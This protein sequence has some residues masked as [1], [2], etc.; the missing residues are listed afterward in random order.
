MQRRSRVLLAGAAIL[1]GLIAGVDFDRTLVAM[2]AWQTVGAS[3]WATFSRQADL[4]NGLVLYPLEAIGAFLLLIAV[5]L[6]L[7][8]DGVPWSR[9]PL[10]LWIAIGASG[11][12]LLLTLVAAPIMFS[13]RAATETALLQAALAD[14]RFFGDV[15]GAFQVLAFVFAVVALTAPNRG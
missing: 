6:S 10:P 9:I 3:A 14:F 12:G 13:I 11:V 4:G 1:S 7:R 5:S 15:R 8:L 2:P